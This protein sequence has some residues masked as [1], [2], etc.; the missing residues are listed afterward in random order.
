MGVHVSDL[1]VAFLELQGQD[2]LVDFLGRVKEVQLEVNHKTKSGLYNRIKFPA[3]LHH[4]TWK[5]IKK[6]FE[7]LNCLRFA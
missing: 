3:L 6:I 2:L 7:H 4:S 1:R 5:V